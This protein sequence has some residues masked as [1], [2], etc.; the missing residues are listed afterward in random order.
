VIVTRVM[1]GSQMIDA[2]NAVVFSRCLARRGMLHSECE[3]V[4]YVRMPAR[5]TFQLTGGAGA[6]SVWLALAGTGWVSAAGA[7][8]PGDVLLA[9]DDGGIAIE[10]GQ[11]GLEFL[12][13]RVLA[14]AASA[15]LPMRRPEI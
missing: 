8:A 11:E 9:P 15:C 12:S 3:A 7:L 13:V 2:N 6:E 5:T 4:D 14:R 10:A 1:S